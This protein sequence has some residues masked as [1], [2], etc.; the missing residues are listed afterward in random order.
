MIDLTQEHSFRAAHEAGE[1]AA[2]AGDKP[3]DCPHERGTVAWIAWT[4]GWEV[5]RRQVAEAVR[6]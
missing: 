3:S 2:Y 4:L 6:E 5:G 1:R